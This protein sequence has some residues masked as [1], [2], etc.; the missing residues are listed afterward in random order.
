MR[1][2]VQ[3][4]YA[5]EPRSGYLYH[6]DAWYHQ[7]NLYFV[8]PFN[9]GMKNITNKA[10]ELDNA[11]SYFTNSFGE[12]S[13]SSRL[14]SDNIEKAAQIQLQPSRVFVPHDKAGTKTDSEP[15]GFFSS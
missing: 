11:L 3:N 10:M 5:H 15:V 8:F 4:L 14:C 7:R 12:M 1:R 6:D 2:F 9:S 13:S